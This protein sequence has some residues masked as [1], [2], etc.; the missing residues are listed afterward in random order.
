[1]REP[2]EEQWTRFHKAISELD[3]MI[4]S[5]KYDFILERAKERFDMVYS[6]Q[7]AVLVMHLIQKGLI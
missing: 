7:V 2:T 4:Q 3:E 1:M 5:G 6:K